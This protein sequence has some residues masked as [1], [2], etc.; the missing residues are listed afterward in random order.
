MSEFKPINK[1]DTEWEEDPAL[2]MSL[3]DILEN[4][5][6]PLSQEVEA[7]LAE[8][9][10]FANMMGGAP[11]DHLCIEAIAL[12]LAHRSAFVQSITGMVWSRFNFR[13]K[14]FLGLPSYP[15]IPGESL[16]TFRSDVTID[17]STEV[18]AT[19]ERV[20]KDSLAHFERNGREYDT[21][22][23]GEDVN[24][25]MDKA[26]HIAQESG[27]PEIQPEHLL[28]AFY[29]AD[30]YEGWHILNAIGRSDPYVGNGLTRSVKPERTNG[31]TVEHIRK[32]IAI[33]RQ[34]L[35]HTP[36]N[37]LEEAERHGVELV[38]NE[39]LLANGVSLS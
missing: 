33:A 39:D 2:D 34:N 16:G 22:K 15:R 23:K 6:H 11:K 32:L 5:T 21:G 9:M 14:E 10:D 35:R 3:E 17:H 24:K 25:L 30:L 37:S 28:L 19:T 4:E 36:Y 18:N 26:A 7:V 31:F 13:Y 29:E 1:D 8:A 20:I 38:S 12:A 27:D